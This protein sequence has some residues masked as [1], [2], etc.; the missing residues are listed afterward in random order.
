VVVNAAYR[1]EPRSRKIYLPFFH[2][3]YLWDN[4]DNSRVGPFGKDSDPE[5]GPRRPG[6]IREDP[7]P[8]DPEQEGADPPPEDRRGRDSP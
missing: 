4:G 8:S 1:I 2:S 6:H 3:F 5:E 7:V